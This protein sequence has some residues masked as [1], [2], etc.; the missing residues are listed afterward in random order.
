VICQLYKETGLT[1]QI[2][3]PGEPEQVDKSGQDTVEGIKTGKV[4]PIRA[5]SGSHEIA[6]KTYPTDY[7]LVEKDPLNKRMTL[8]SK[9]PNSFKESTDIVMF[10]TT[11]GS[12]G[13]AEKQIRDT[14]EAVIKG[15][16]VTRTPALVLAHWT[17]INDSLRG[18]YNLLVSSWGY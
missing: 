17:K 8:E 13:E 7:A 4:L 6:G 15:E 1:V 3:I 2:Q 18:E 12:I 5:P 14:A 16:F 10:I 11:I 9:C